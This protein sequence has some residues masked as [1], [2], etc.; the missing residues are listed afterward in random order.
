MLRK[1]HQK[2]CEKNKWTFNILE[3]IGDQTIRRSVAKVSGVGAFDFFKN[4]KGVHKLT[5]VSPFGRGKKHTSCVAVSVFKD[6]VKIDCAIPDK[7]LKWDTFRGTGAG[8]QHRNKRD[9]AVRL[10]HL[11]TNTVVTVLSG[12]SQFQNKENALKELRDRLFK[13]NQANTHSQKFADVNREALG[14][15]HQVRSYKLDQNLIKDERTGIVSKKVE[16]IMGGDLS[17][18]C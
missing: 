17:L 3:S 15:G 1:L 10:T 13:A 2:W 18:F 6:S 8:G 9:T 11:P 5:R 4:E 7:D 14:F 12:R 16:H